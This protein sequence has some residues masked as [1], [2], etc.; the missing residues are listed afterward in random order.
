[1]EWINS[2]LIEHSVIQ[3]VVV[4]A[5]ISALGLAL[6]KISVYGVSLGVTFVFFVGIAAGHF[7]LSIDPQMLNYAE[8]FGLI[9]FVY[10]LGLQVGPGF[11][12]SFRKGG[13][14]LNMLAFAVIL[15]GTAMTLPRRNLLDFGPSCGDRRVVARYGWYIEWCCNQY[16]CFG[17]CTANFE[18]DAYRCG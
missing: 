13:M 7:G 8:S 10:A 15:V 6:G 4:I 17:G 1:M 16:P 12:G 9:I 18:A 11:F 2:I 14:T 5:M 3:A